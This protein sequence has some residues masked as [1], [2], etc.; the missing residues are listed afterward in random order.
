MYAVVTAGNRQF[1][2]F[3]GDV[4]QVEKIDAPVGDTVELDQVRMLV[5]DDGIV[6]NPEALAGAKVVCHVVGQ[7][8][9]R[10]V[11]VFKKKRKK[12]YTRLHGHRQA[13][14]ALKVAEIVG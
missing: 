3:P 2:V 7:G 8:R 10:K 4:F 6:V 14:T 11:R 9:S 12:N 1:K 5:K 13:F